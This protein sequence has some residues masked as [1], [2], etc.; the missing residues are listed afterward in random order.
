VASRIDGDIKVPCKR[1]PSKQPRVLTAWYGDKAG[2]TDLSRKQREKAAG[3]KPWRRQ[4]L[5]PLVSLLYC[6]PCS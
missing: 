4:E 5:S 6:Y 2:D 3:T 1:S